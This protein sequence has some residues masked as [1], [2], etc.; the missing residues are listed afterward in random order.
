MERSGSKPGMDGHGRSQWAPQVTPGPNGAVAPWVTV[1]AN[2]SHGYVCEWDNAAPGVKP[3]VPAAKADAP[4][5]GPGGIPNGDFEQG[6]LG[7]WKTVR[8]VKIL[9]KVKKK[10]TIRSKFPS[11]DFCAV[12]NASLVYQTVK[13]KPGTSYEFSA[14]VNIV[15]PPDT[16]AICIDEWQRGPT[17]DAPLNVTRK[18]QPIAVRFKATKPEHK[19]IL[20]CH[21]TGQVL[22]DDLELK[23]VE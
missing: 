5:P 6:V 17:Q 16:V 22:I 9:R 18:W 4:A 12:L 20:L 11:G 13:V 23:P 2:Q 1:D 15:D 10:G 21:R 8:E 3:A 19:V 7:P 14:W